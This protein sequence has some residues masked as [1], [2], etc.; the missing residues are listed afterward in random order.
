MSAPPRPAT[1]FPWILLAS[2]LGFILLIVALAVYAPP[3]LRNGMLRGTAVVLMV[4]LVMLVARYMLLLWLGYLHHVESMMAERGDRPTD[5][6]PPVSILVPAFNEGVSIEPSVRSL[7]R[8]EYPVYEIIVLDDGST[9]D[10]YERAVAFEGQWGGASVRVIRKSN[11]GKAA[12]LNYGIQIARYPFVLCM[13][14]DSKLTD[15]TL[16]RMAPHFQD[17]DVAAV[18]GNVKVINRRGLWARVQ[19]LEYIEGLNMARRA[20]GFMRAVNII[21]GPGGRFRREVM[22]DL[23]GYEYDTYAEDADFTLKILAAG[24]RIVYEDRAIAWTEAPEA[25]L[26]LIKQRYRWT[27]GII[28]ALRKRKRVFIHPTNAMTWFSVVMMC[29]ESLIWPA[30]NIFGTLFFLVVAI[31]FGAGQYLLA[32]WILLTILDVAAAL[33]TVVMEGEDLSLVPLAVFYRLVFVLLIDITKLFATVEEFMDVQMSWG[34]LE[35][36]GRIT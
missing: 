22:I 32:W 33:H 11:S 21:P 25:L 19:A 36:L 30:L 3:G 10:T 20:Q 27:R 6:H 35:R 7:L 17:P 26:S 1:R 16:R 31:S 28:Q 4:F 18:A 29:F 12:T 14:G 8:M 2:S 9:D 13:D 23:G 5:F 34:K 15:D 24:W